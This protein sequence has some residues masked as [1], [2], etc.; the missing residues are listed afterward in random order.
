MLNDNIYVL[1]PEPE[2]EDGLEYWWSLFV[3]LLTHYHYHLHLQLDIC[4][5]CIRKNCHEHHV[6]QRVIKN[7]ED[8]INKVIKY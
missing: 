4:L 2:S 8:D 5:M 3:T 6:M 1:N 7:E